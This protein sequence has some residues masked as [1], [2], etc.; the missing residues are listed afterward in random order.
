MFDR[1][2]NAPFSPSFAKA[3]AAWGFAGIALVALFLHYRWASRK[4]MCDGEE[5]GSDE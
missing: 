3:D 5:N 2:E 1:L 4:K